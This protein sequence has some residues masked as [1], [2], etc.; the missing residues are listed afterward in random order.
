[1]CS[2]LSSKLKKKRFSFLYS[3]KFENWFGCFQILILRG[4]FVQKS[5]YNW[6]WYCVHIDIILTLC[7]C[8]VRCQMVVNF[9]MH[10]QKNLF[11]G[12]YLWK[13]PLKNASLT[14]KWLIC[15]VVMGRCIHW[16]NNP[17][18]MYI[19]CK[20]STVSLFFKINCLASIFNRKKIIRPHFFSY[21]KL[22]NV[23]VN[24]NHKPFLDHLFHWV[25]INVY[26]FLFPKSDMGL[27][28]L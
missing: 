11:V 13:V 28:T 18:S 26:F 14:H 23:T 7:A 19:L 10:V 24:V 17:E 15:C 20:F 21:K 16:K 1:M 27:M 25:C 9:T 3:A 4:F 5:Q 2:I 12:L 22:F 6:P 8:Q